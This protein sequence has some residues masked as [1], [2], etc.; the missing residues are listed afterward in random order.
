MGVQVFRWT[1]WFEVDRLLNRMMASNGLPIV[2]IVILTMATIQKDCVVSKKTCFS[3]QQ[4][5]ENNK[6]LLNFNIIANKKRK[7]IHC[8]VDLVDFASL[9]WTKHQMYVGLEATKKPNMR[10]ISLRNFIM[11]HRCFNTFGNDTWIDPSQC[12]MYIHIYIHTQP[13]PVVCLFFSGISQNRPHAST[14]L[15]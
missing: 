15:P 1:G 12:I 8:F 14:F 9:G 6:R 13:V 5:E 3:L 7:K 4:L 11:L 10:S 2:K